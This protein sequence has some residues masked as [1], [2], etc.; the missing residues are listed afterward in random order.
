VN[1]FPG[2]RSGGGRASL[3][4]LSLAAGCTDVLSFLELGNLFTSAM[5]GNT[6]LLAVAI[7]RGEWSA[8]LHALCALVAF[9][10]GVSIATVVLR[11]FRRL[12]L[13]EL[14][15]LGICATLWSVGPR[16][17]GGG[18][19]Y[20]VIALSAVSM[21]IQA[22]GARLIDSEGISTVVFTSVLVRIVM[23]ATAALLRRGPVP[24]ASS[25]A[26]ARVD[27]FAAYGGGGVV[28]ALL[29]SRHLG[30]AI[31]MPFAAVVLALGA[32]RAA[33]Q[34]PSSPQA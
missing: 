8:A 6:A 26:R 33:A 12:L 18:L 23:S 9:S 27:T 2:G 24:A 11:S 32:S 31:W 3:F 25:G 10:L 17:L 7:G 28:A 16:P 30:T 20:A 13:V 15:V 29:V 14:V 19:L 5:T 22:V 34:L 1:V 4:W 21:G